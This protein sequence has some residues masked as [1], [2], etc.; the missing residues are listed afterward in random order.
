LKCEISFLIFE[1]MVSIDL[2]YLIIENQFV[3]FIK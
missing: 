2:G 1:S 3:K